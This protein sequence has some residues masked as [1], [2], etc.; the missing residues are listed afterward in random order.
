MSLNGGKKARWTK[1]SSAA[2]LLR[3]DFVSGAIAPE[4]FNVKDVHQ[5][6]PEYL[7]YELS[8]F[9]RNISQL[10]KDFVKAV[11]A[12]S[13]S[14]DRWLEGGKPPADQGKQKKK[15]N[16]LIYEMTHLFFVSSFFFVNFSCEKTDCGNCRVRSGPAFF[17]LPSD[18][19]LFS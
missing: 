5:S 2:K 14:L 7:E 17:F 6:R 9:S 8:S 16:A 18:P 13:S 3:Q 12:G 11:E 10:S 15:F 1:S 4:S 19:E